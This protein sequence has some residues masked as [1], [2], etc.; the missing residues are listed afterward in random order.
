MRKEKLEKKKKFVREKK[1]NSQKSI[2]DICFYM[3]IIRALK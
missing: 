2:H 1:I 3:S